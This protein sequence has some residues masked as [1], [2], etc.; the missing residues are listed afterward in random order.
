M[1]LAGVV[2]CTTA[3]AGVVSEPPG[4]CTR[5]TGFVIS[6]IMYK[7]ATTNALE[8]V[9]I[10]NSNPFEEEIGGY[11]IEGEIEFTFP[12]GTMLAGQSYLVLAKDATAFDEAY[13]L[14]GVQ[15]FEYGASDGSNSLASSGSLR[16]INSCD[17]TVLEI[18][19]ANEAPWPVAADGAGHSIVLARPSYGE[20]DP[21]A[22][23]A[24][25]QF[26]GSPGSGESYGDTLLRNVV[27]NEILAHTDD[28]QL[29]TIELYNHSN[30]SVD[31]SGC[32]LSD[33][34]AANKFT[35]PEGTIV[36]ARGFLV[37]DEVQLG[38]SLD[39]SGESL[40]FRNP[41]GT[42]ML[43]SVEFGGQ[44]NGIS[45]GRYP[46]GGPEFH[47]MAGLTPGAANG[48]RR[49][50]D[51]VINEIMY[52]PISGDADDEFVELHNHGA[53]TVDLG[54]WR[55]RGGI[56]FTF[57]DG[58]LI[59]PGG[60]VVVARNAAQLQA[61]H[62]QLGASNT[63]GNFT[64][65]LG[66][67]GDRVTLD[68]PDIQTD[69]T[70]PSNPVTTVIHIRVDE[71]SYQTGG[72]WPVWAKG[73]GSSLERVDPRAN[74]RRPTAWADSD[75][76]GKADWTTISVTGLQELG[77]R[78]ASRI[79]GGLQGAGE[80][81]LDDVQVVH[82]NT[83]YVDN[84]NFDGGL[85]NWVASGAFERSSQDSAGVGGSSC[86]HIRASTRYDTGANQVS[87]SLSSNIPE[88]VT[89]TISAKAK[90]QKGYPWMYLR[91]HGN[92]LEAPVRLDVPANLGTPGQANSRAAAN[93][94]PAIDEVAHSPAVPSAGQSVVVTARA[95]DPDGL[96]TLS[97]HY[98]VDP[99]GTYASLA[100]ND[101]G[102]SG[103]A[104]AGDGI[105]SATIP[106]QSTGTLVAFLLTATDSAG[107]PAR[108]FPSNT[109]ANSPRIRECLVRFGDATRASSF[110][111]YRMWFTAAA[112]TDWETRRALSNEPVEG[113]FVYN[114]TRVIHNFRAHYAGSPFHQ[115]WTSITGDCHYTMDMPLDDKLL[116]TDNFNKLHAP[117]NNPFQDKTM[118]REQAGFWVAR[119]LKL[120]WL[121]RRYVNVYVNGV[122]RQAGMLMED[123]QVPGSEFIEQYWRNDAD[124]N[125]HKANFWWEYSN[126]A[127]ATGTELNEQRQPGTELLPYLNAAGDLHAPRYRWN[128]TPRA[129]GDTGGNDF[130]PVLDLIEAANAGTD[131]TDRMM[132]EADMEEWMRIW[133]LRH[134]VGDPDHF[135]CQIAQNMYMYKP[136]AG[137]WALMIWD[138]NHLFGNNLSYGP[139]RG[140]FPDYSDYG[141]DTTLTAVYEN[142]TFRR[143]YL[144]ALKE[145]SNGPFQ[146]P[147]IDQ[148]LD[149]RFQAFIADGLGS[150]IPAM[151]PDA[152]FSY[153]ESRSSVYDGGATAKFTGSFK[154]W[155]AEARTGILAR[156]A[157]EDTAD[158]ALTT[159]SSVTA[160][161]NV[162][163][164]TGTA[165]VELASMTINGVAYPVTWTSVTE[166]TVDVVVDSSPAAFVLQGLDVYGNPL[167]GATATVTVTLTGSGLDAPGDSIVINEILYNP[168]APG[169]AFVELHN[170]STHTTFD[171]TGWRLDGL[172]YTF[173]AT[174]L[175]PGDFLTID[176]L[177]GTLDPDGETLTLYRPA[178]AS[179]EETVVD[180]VRY[181]NVDPW[182]VTAAGTSLQL[183][184]AAQD[185]RRAA[186]W[187]AASGFATP[188]DGATLIDW[189]ET[190]K[191]R[192]GVNL[193]GTG[194]QTSDYDDSSWPSGPAAFGLEGATLPHPLQTPFTLGTI[195][196]Y[197][198][199]TIE[200]TGDAGASLV[201]TTMVDDGLVVY[202]DGVEIHRLRMP[203]G[204]PTYTTQ[205]TSYVDNATEEGPV[206]V[207]MNL[208][209]GTHVIAVEL[210]QT[211]TASSD[212]VFDMRV[213]TDYT[214]L[215]AV[216]ATPGAANNVSY[217]RADIPA[218]WL[219]EVMPNPTSGVPWVEL[220]NAGST[221]VSLDGHALSD[222]YAD[223]GK[224][225]VT[226]GI[227]IQPG[228]FLQLELPS[229]ALAG[230]SVV[231]S[232]DLAGTPEII[233]YLNHGSL[234]AD[235]SYGNHPDGDPCS[236]IAMV[237]PTPGAANTNQSAPLA[238]RI[239]EWM[240]DNSSTL[241][242]PIDGNY[243]DW[244]EIHNPGNTAVD[245]GGYFLTDDLTAP[246]QFEIPSSGKYT[247]PARGFLLV[248]ADNE[249]EQ[250]D[251]D[252]SALHVNFA[253]SKNGEAIAL[254]A[255][256]GSVIDSVTFAAQSPDQ[257]EGRLPDGGDS[258]AAM[259]PS[260]GLANPVVNTAPEL[261]PI[262]DGWFYAG[263]SISIAAS[264][265]DAESDSQSLAYS[266]DPGAP[267]GAAVTPAGAFSWIV[268]A[269]M[270]PSDWQ[271]TIRVT[272]NGT[273]PLSDTVTF[274][275]HI[276]ALPVVGSSVTPGG[277]QLT[278]RIETIPG[279]DYSLYYN[280]SLSETQW[281]PLG[282]TE[283][284]D[285][286]PLQWQVPVTDA[287]QRFYR[288]SID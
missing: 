254:I 150:G 66:N 105:F 196:Y 104:I 162:V 245:L 185:N 209:P 89:A 7:P 29:D 194:W 42:R 63:Y 256:D 26:G 204:T 32:T 20:N 85:A 186:L 238:V 277:D 274:T 177:D 47:R 128:W 235:W 170:R 265:T 173:P 110:G 129:Y 242:D 91:L 284:G 37:F 10:Y 67:G 198:R 125:L 232:R 193:D 244:F 159:P 267:A 187:A 276:N 218:L 250:N 139:G 83:N 71:V 52:D 79:E 50:D 243:E 273:P 248:W 219:N 101:L 88:G 99:L 175:A 82:D 283:H 121:Y 109:P 285:G 21:Q 269:D 58:A 208:Q 16:M 141:D 216:V 169:G 2:A 257:S 234:T 212:V 54:G 156:I 46:D 135:G 200:F 100:M 8:F 115:N 201:L 259:T 30:S 140:L 24:G 205:T 217:T 202:V 17:G 68:K 222:D 164:I 78:G 127:T 282:N 168:Q 158:F 70:D 33:D 190:W 178:G 14:S 210:H 96:A 255:P 270:P 167:A 253:L 249:P 64:G 31:L 252:A 12:Q 118:T 191:Y 92:Y 147:E 171:L 247:V 98:R 61:N 231:L 160:S 215:A 192:Q 165:P 87:G 157:Q 271:P 263:E 181:E 146:G 226:A 3:I 111:T 130:S 75:E 155:L 131:M 55:L 134:A 228:G 57:P 211:T 62:T 19:Y 278:L 25:D 49:I 108:V 260:P 65:K 281:L 5:K 161:D 22:W 59:S 97:L 132:A 180:Q 90:W 60:Y 51:V 80:C 189:G 38:F 183:M 6:E 163:T 275:L 72:Q 84:P 4:A 18:D 53:A 11:R 107:S 35:I 176:G 48:D 44:E 203:A 13:G 113:T 76:T 138:M 56:S 199:K 137:R 73:G 136:T 172:A 39:S 224:W 197:F 95:E 258:I 81:L 206:E 195:T 69:T 179:G 1:L 74:P 279:H 266:L 45:I 233:D 133:A 151:S 34:P 184:D 143:M 182:P 239:N 207:A 106:G 102:V 40:Y 154:D 27:I 251:L 77:A 268:P 120:P 86:L 241:A 236:R 103:D 246:Y 116:G 174:V 122:A 287:P 93:A 43:D 41:A 126:V 23:E 288:F 148:W 15:V 149:V 123:T 9:E 262:A 221:A 117:G 240:A 153:S 272:D 227:S 229:G 230:G 280:D 225:P 142:P 237:V 144:R 213:A 36:A 28:P 166:W 220:H 264:A 119:Q 286:T 152:S 145:I 94:A 261:N 214:A 114:D 223:P 112:T 124:G 188:P